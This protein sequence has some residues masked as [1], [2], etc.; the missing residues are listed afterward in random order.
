MT[1]KQEFLKAIWEGE[2]GQQDENGITVSLREF[3]QYFKHIESG[4]LTS[5]LPASVIEE[6]QFSVTHTR[7]LFRVKKGVYKIHPDALQEYA[8]LSGQTT[9]DIW[10]HKTPHK[11]VDFLSLRF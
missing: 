9:K 3:R 8:L 1:L 10:Q 5:F 4:Y 6:G 7:F 2:L 11:T